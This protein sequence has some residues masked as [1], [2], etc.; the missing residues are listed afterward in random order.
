MTDL[1]PVVDDYLRAQCAWW[2]KHCKSISLWFLSMSNNDQ[3]QILLHACPSMPVESY[4]SRLSRGEKIQPTDVLVPELSQRGL[5][6]ANGRCLILFL[7]RRNVNINDMCMA[8]D[9][10]QMNTLK[11]TMMLPDFSQGLCN[12]PQCPYVNPMDAAETVYQLANNAAT[13]STDKSSSSVKEMNSS[14]KATNLPTPPPTTIATSSSTPTPPPAATPLTATPEDIQ[15][16]MR[17]GLLVRL[18]VWLAVKLRRQTLCHFVAAIAEAH[19]Q[20]IKDLYPNGTVA[21]H[22]NTNSASND[23]TDTDAATVSP[24]NIH[25]MSVSPSYSQL[26]RSEIAQ[27]T[28]T[29][30]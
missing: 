28:L 22:P 6:E 10:K 23:S 24:D 2:G 5:L 20:F 11:D 12:G 30:E 3:L 9:I 7:T 26:L 18:D 21:D 25:K 13:A 1:E 29:H 14:N 19:E 8:N 4:V 27:R 16:R 17:L 15:E